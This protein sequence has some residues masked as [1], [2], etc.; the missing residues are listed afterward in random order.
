MTAR[1]V[2]TATLSVI[3]ALLSTPVSAQDGLLARASVPISISTSTTTQLVALA[4]GQP[5][6]V[7]SWDVVTA[8]SGT[9][10]LVYGTGT[11]CATGQNTLTGAYPMAAQTVITRGSGNGVILVVPAGN[12]L[13]VVT[14]GAVQ[15]SGSLSYVQ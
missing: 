9:F 11:S 1:I 2:T 4:A 5:I 13:C 7:L 12:A 14:V 8:G 10:Q 3:A 15:Y 6:Y